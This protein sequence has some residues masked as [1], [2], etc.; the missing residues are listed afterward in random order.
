MLSQ[1]ANT[2]LIRVPPKVRIGDRWLMPSKR[3]VEI[4]RIV[5]DRRPVIVAK[6]VG[7]DARPNEEIEYPLSSLL[8]HGV[9][10]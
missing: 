10:A 9:A 7:P 6:Y 8:R 5:G 4:R 2:T 3:L 1:I